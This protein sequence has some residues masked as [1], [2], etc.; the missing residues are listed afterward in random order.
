MLCVGGGGWNAAISGGVSEEGAA[1]AT[2]RRRRALGACP[3]SRG[4]LGWLVQT[5]PAERGSSSS[6]PA[7]HTDKQRC[8]RPRTVS[9]GP[10]I[11]S[12]EHRRDPGDRRRRTLGRGACPRRGYQLHSVAVPFRRL[13]RTVG[14]PKK[15][16]RWASERLRVECGPARRRR[17]E[18]SHGGHV[19]SLG[20]IDWGPLIGCLLAVVCDV[21][22][23]VVSVVCVNWRQARRGG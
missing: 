6:G 4:A 9:I 14:P 11:R 2:T 5:D 3:S 10:S 13:R 22:G 1:A 15:T 8:C 12:K 16:G 19:H 18:A 21:V 7:T 23:C 20:W 17:G